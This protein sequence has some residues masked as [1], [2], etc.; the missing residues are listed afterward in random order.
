MTKEEIIIDKIRQILGWLPHSAYSV[1]YVD[2]NAVQEI[3]LSLSPEEGE[4][5]INELENI[6]LLEVDK[7][8]AALRLLSL[9]DA[10]CLLLARANIIQKSEAILKAKGMLTLEEMAY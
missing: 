9:R 7:H 6:M 3:I 1:K 4:A 5:Y 10:R 2:H 8:L